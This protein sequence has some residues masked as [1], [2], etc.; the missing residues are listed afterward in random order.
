[1][2]IKTLMMSLALS[3]GCLAAFASSNDVAKMEPLPFKSVQLL[4]TTEI[5]SKPVTN[6]CTVTVKY[7]KT[8]ITITNSC[9]CSMREACNGA[10]QIATILL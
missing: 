1:M 2:K 7:G 9:D 10:Y 8:N 6:T 5:V 4:K 3:I